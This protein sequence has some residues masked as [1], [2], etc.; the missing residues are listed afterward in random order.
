MQVYQESLLKLYKM[1]RG[2]KQV[3]VVQ[4]VNVLL[5]PGSVSGAASPAG[6]ILSVAN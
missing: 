2:G 4:H 5:R 3:V 6:V 1:R